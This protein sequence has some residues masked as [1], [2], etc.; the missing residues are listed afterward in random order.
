MLCY[1]AGVRRTNI[2]YEQAIYT[3]PVQNIHVI[4]YL[5]KKNYFLSFF[6]KRS[7]RHMSPCPQPCAPHSH[8]KRTMLLLHTHTAGKAAKKGTG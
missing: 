3:L 4:C 7:Y 2:C 1:I 8:T 6:L 5:H